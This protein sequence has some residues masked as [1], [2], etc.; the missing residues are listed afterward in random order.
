MRHLGLEG[1]PSRASYISKSPD[2]S[3]VSL[4]LKRVSDRKAVPGLEHGHN[5]HQASRWVCLSN[6]GDRLV[7]SVCIVKPS[8]KQPRGFILSRSIERGLRSAWS[9]GDFQYGSGIAIHL[10]RICRSSG[11]SRYPVQRG[12]SWSSFRQCFCREAVE[13]IEA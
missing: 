9:T 12:R 7:Q 6:G 1:C 13:V 8:F 3:K 4:S 5:L 2:P 11:K 10:C